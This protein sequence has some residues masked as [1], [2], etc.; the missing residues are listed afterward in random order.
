MNDLNGTRHD[1]VGITAFIGRD[2]SHA[3]HA[4]AA[5]YAI[6]NCSAMHIPG[7]HHILISYDLPSLSTGAPTRTGASFFSPGLARFVRPRPHA[8]STN[9]VHSHRELTSKRHTSPSSKP[10]VSENNDRPQPRFVKRSR[11]CLLLIYRRADVR[12]DSIPECHRLRTRGTVDKA[13]PARP[14]TR[15][16]HLEFP[17]VPF[18]L[19]S[20]GSP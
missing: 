14:S 8:S 1:F 4:H 7:L 17:S 11:K 15:Q 10:Q 9:E 6:F 16:A 18:E 5:R 20:T 2:A 3:R 12:L 13:A 19:L